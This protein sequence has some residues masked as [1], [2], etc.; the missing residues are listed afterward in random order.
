MQL[1]IELRRRARHAIFP[2][3]SACAIFYFGYHAV[4]GEY[5]LGAYLKLHKQIAALQVEH[6]DLVAQRTELEHRVSLLRPDSLDPDMLDE[7]ARALLGFAHPDDLV[8]LNAK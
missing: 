4:H 5:G 7:R 2:L 8:I 3:L 6:T 1:A